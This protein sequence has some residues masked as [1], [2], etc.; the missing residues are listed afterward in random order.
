MFSGTGRFQ[1]PGW[2]KKSCWCAPN[3]SGLMWKRKR[4]EFRAPVCA[5]QARKPSCRGHHTQLF[6]GPAWSRETAGSAGEGLAANARCFACTAPCLQRLQSPPW[7]GPGLQLTAQGLLFSLPQR[8]D[9]LTALTHPRW[10]HSASHCR[11]SSTTQ[12]AR[13]TH[14]PSQIPL[15]AHPPSTAQPPTT[16]WPGHVPAMAAPKE[17]SRHPVRLPLVPAVRAGLAEG[18]RE[19]REGPS[20]SL[21]W[22][23]S[24]GMW[25]SQQQLVLGP[26]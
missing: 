22:H 26:S 16:C 2:K 23:G 20:P 14:S 8:S 4:V 6:P 17:A 18:S 24:M 25:L 12:Q 11:L 13:G 3:F 21:G 10:C 19:T 9:P 15:P 5:K 1:P 7:L